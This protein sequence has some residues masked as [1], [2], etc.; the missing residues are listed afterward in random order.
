MKYTVDL[1][2]KIY[3]KLKINYW[4]KLQTF[5]MYLYSQLKRC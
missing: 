4:L 2:L 1:E 3:R 5:Y